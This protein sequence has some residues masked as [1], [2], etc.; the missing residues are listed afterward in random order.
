MM[1]YG[2]FSGMF[3]RLQK[4]TLVAAG[5]GSKP[6]YEDAKAVIQLLFGFSKHLAYQHSGMFRI[7]YCGTMHLRMVSGLTA[8]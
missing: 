4:V 2:H 6:M 3:L 5:H 1:A 8:F 7:V